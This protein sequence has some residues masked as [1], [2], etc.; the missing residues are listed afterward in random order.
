[1]SSRNRRRKRDLP[2][3]VSDSIAEIR[4]PRGVKLHPTDHRGDGETPPTRR[5]R[6]AR[7]RHALKGERPSRGSRPEK[8]H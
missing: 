4:G 5:P 8:S 3:G 6:S 2:G 1:M 7:E